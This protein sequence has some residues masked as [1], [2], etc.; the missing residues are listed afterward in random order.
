MRKDS[1]TGPVFDENLVLKL[2]GA[3]F[4]PQYLKCSQAVRN[5]KDTFKYCVPQTPKCTFVV[6]YAPKHSDYKETH[7]G[8][9]HS[10]F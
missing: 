3:L 2:E 9:P 6:C 8:M 5:S 10:L 7:K 1:T 4:M